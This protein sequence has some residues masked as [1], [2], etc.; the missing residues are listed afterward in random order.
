MLLQDNSSFVG[1]VIAPFH[2]LTGVLSVSA[3]LQQ[4]GFGETAPA[5]FCTS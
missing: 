3:W 1:V 2:S 4:S 5:R